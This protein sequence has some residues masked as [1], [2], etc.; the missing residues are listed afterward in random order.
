L[1]RLHSQT[2]LSALASW[3]IHSRTDSISPFLTEVPVRDRENLI[4]DRRSSAFVHSHGAAPALTDAINCRCHFGI[5]RKRQQQRRAIM[6]GSGGSWQSVVQMAV[7]TSLLCF[8]LI[9][10]AF[11]VEVPP[12]GILTAAAAQ[13]P[14]NAKPSAPAVP[15]VSDDVA[16]STPDLTNMEA[17]PEGLP[18]I[19]NHAIAAALADGISTKL[20]LSAGALEA[21]PM[22]LSFPMGL[23]ALT[24]AKVL[25]A[26]YAN[27]LPEK[28]KRLVI[29][30][31]SSAWGG[32][33]VNNLL[34]FMAAPPPIPIVA[35]VL[36]GILVWH[37]T[38][39]DYDNRD[40]LAALQKAR[41]PSGPVQASL[42]PPPGLAP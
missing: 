11:Q 38:G 14:E 8:P 16:P 27:K 28:E 33:A 17:R 6:S 2:N 40:R 41:L 30:T 32:A 1:Q 22:A 39:R 42:E 19:R 13:T 35:G 7:G 15:L 37:Q 10:V 12:E 34:V 23:A 24:G 29:K 5:D 4:C 3:L 36:M 26:V 21:N 20:A 25:V 9:C 18:N 31:S